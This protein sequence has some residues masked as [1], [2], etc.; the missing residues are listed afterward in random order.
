MRFFIIAL[1]FVGCSQ[2]IESPRPDFDHALASYAKE[3]YHSG[4][5]FERTAIL[6]DSWCVF[7]GDKAIDSKACEFLDSTLQRGNGY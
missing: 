7:L 1:L 4:E 2:P 3:Q 5:A 6:L